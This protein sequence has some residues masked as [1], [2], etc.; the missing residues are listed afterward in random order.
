LKLLKLIGGEYQGFGRCI[1][2]E[3][4][5]RKGARQILSSAGGLSTMGPGGAFH[6]RRST[7]VFIELGMLAGIVVA[8]Y[9]LPGTTSLAV[10][11]LATGV[12]FVAGNIL[13]VRKIK[14]IK[15]GNRPAEDGPW[16]YLFRALAVLSAAWLLSFLLFKR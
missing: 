16:P 4:S 3:D 15:V 12:C 7:I 1:P 9:A 5:E 13:L 2:C 10:F 8:G 11:L 6:L 14:Q